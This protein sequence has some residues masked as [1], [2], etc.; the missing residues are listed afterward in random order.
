[1]FGITTLIDY[2][3]FIHGLSVLSIGTFK[4]KSYGMILFQNWKLLLRKQGC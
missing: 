1:M 4:F 2:G 3:P